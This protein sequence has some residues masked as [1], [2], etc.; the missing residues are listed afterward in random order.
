MCFSWK[1]LSI[2]YKVDISKY[3]IWAEG[4]WTFCHF[5]ADCYIIRFS[6]WSTIGNT[7]GNSTVI[8]VKP[9]IALVKNQVKVNV[10]AMER[11]FCS[12][13]LCF[14]IAFAMKIYFWSGSSAGIVHLGHFSF[15]VL[16]S[17]RLTHAPKI[18]FC[19]TKWIHLLP[20]YP[21]N[22]QELLLERTAADTSVPRKSRGIHCRW[23]TLGF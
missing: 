13:A 14:L 15:R 7:K 20:S 10:V 16:Y 17:E 3:E 23:G 21:V 2:L 19:A 8:V 6:K 18:I 11:S 4:M 12:L 9:L 5:G 22:H 1:S